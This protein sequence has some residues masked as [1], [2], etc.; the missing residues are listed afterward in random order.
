MIVTTFVAEPE[1]KKEEPKHYWQP[2][3]ALEKYRNTLRG[4]KGNEDIAEVC[5][6]FYEDL[7]KSRQNQLN[8]D[9]CIFE[10]RLDTFTYFSSIRCEK[11]YGQ[12]IKLLSS[13]CQ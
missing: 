3:Y 7:F 9:K 2:Q 6:A 5:A 10:S 4:P 13:S 8:L 1:P 11:E 12:T